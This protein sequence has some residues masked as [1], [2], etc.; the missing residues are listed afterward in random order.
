AASVGAGVCGGVVVGGP[1]L[2]YWAG[3]HGRNPMRYLGGMLGGT[4]LTAMAGD[5]GHGIFDGANLVANFESLNPANTYWEKPHHLYAN[6]DSEA[7]RFLDFETCRGNP[8][9]LN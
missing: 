9:L 8:V 5:L 6:V 4:W 3:V 1:P 7:P 2:S